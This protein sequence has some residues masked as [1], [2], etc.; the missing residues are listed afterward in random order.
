M[1]LKAFYDEQVE[2][3]NT[4]NAQA[5]VEAHYAENAMM[6]VNSVEPP[7]VAQG[8]EQ[9]V[10]LFSNYLEYVYRGFVSTNKYVETADSIFFEATIDTVNGHLDVYDAMILENGK[11]VRH[12]SGVK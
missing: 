4:K 3:L 8:H 11:I 1:D 7:I 12:F 2:I 9:L 6:V 5:L 10:G